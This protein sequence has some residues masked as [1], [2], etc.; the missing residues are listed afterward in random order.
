MADQKTLDRVAKLLRLA[1]PK[2]GAPEPERASA[3][4]ECAKII[5]EHGL[6]VVVPP[7]PPKRRRAPAPTPAPIYHAPRYPRSNSN[8]TEASPLWAVSCI[9]CGRLIQPE[10]S[11]FVDIMQGWRCYQIDCDDFPR[12]V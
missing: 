11:A 1:D 12:S 8:W 9:M 2:S 3:A 4:L 7:T 6:S 5:A 10:E